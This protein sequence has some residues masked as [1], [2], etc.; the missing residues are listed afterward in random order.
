MGIK[1]VFYTSF[2]DVAANSPFEF[3][4]IHAKTEAFIKKSGLIYTILRN[5]L[6]AD[7]LARLTPDANDCI[8]L[9]AAGERVAFISREDIATFAVKVLLK[10]EI[11]QNKI[12][13]L[14]GS[15]AYSF[16]EI[17]ELITKRNKK[18][19]SYVPDTPEKFTNKLVQSGM[20]E[21]V[22]H[23]V[24]SMYEAVSDQKLGYAKVSPD[25]EKVVGRSTQDISLFLP[26]LG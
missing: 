26:H 25:F 3:S 9:P 16:F 2:I 20:P 22:S 11:H 4:A 24:T 1:H 8:S 17:A 12:Y 6:Y 21:W 15:K 7:F 13:K 10:S 23:A 14:T 5:N 18:I 19:I